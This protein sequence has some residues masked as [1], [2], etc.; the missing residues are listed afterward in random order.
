MHDCYICSYWRA[1]YREAKLCRIC[2][3]NS[4]TNASA[5][6]KWLLQTDF[7]M[8]GQNRT[9]VQN[10]AL[11][12][13]AIYNRMVDLIRL[14][15]P[16]AWSPQIGTF[17]KHD[18]L[19][20]HLWIGTWLP[21]ECEVLSLVTR[22]FGNVRDTGRVSTSSRFCKAMS[23]CQRRALRVDEFEVAWVGL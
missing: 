2:W 18:I 7:C 20:A 16:Q 8:P 19:P 13:V 5:T 23:S 22:C 1:S 3:H 17:F 9:V 12:N 11:E 10:N 15:A 14:E 4:N 21:E 6:N